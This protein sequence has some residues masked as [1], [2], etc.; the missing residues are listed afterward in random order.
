[1]SNKEQH[2]KRNLFKDANRSISGLLLFSCAKERLIVAGSNRANLMNNNVVT[3][4][5]RRL[6]CGKF[7]FLYMQFVEFRSKSDAHRL[8]E[9]ASVFARIRRFPTYANSICKLTYKPS[10]NGA[11]QCLVSIVHVEPALKSAGK[12]YLWP[13]KSQA[14]IHRIHAP[15]SYSAK[16]ILSIKLNEFNSCFRPFAL[17]LLS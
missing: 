4:Y 14:V 8:V 15:G 7:H 10:S 3:T 9:P 5:K 11:A 16:N 13:Y 12:T 2:S 6:L 17:M 1:M